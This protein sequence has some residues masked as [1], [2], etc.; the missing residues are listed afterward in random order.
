MS[1]IYSPNSGATISQNL[2]MTP[3][4]LPLLSPTHFITATNASCTTG[5]GRACYRKPAF[6]ESAKNYL[7]LPSPNCSAPTAIPFETGNAE[8][9]VLCLLRSELQHAQNNL[10][11]K[12]KSDHTAKCGVNLIFCLCFIDFLV[13]AQGCAIFLCSALKDHHIESMSTSSS[14]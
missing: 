4:K 7:V 12:T 1:Y 13:Y 11:L 14:Q 10:D 2:P 5:R 3:K 6:T 8:Q 9:I